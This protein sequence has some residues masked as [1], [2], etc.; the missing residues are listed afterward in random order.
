M[1]VITIFLGVAFFFLNDSENEF[2]NSHFQKMFV[3]AGIIFGLTA[4][5]LL[6]LLGNTEF[7]HS[8]LG[9]VPYNRGGSIAVYITSICIPFYFCFV[10][11][12]NSRMEEKIDLL[13]QMDKIELY[14]SYYLL[15]FILFIVMII[16]M[17]ISIL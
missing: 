14:F 6:T 7:L 1:A 8:L 13:N 3:V 9:H 4:L 12:K 2:R 17:I 15:I 10:F 5:T 16:G 11:L